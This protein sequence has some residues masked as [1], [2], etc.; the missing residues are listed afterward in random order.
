MLLTLERPKDIDLESLL[1]VWVKIAPADNGVAVLPWKKVMLGE[2]DVSWVVTEP[3]TITQ[4]F[5]RWPNGRTERFSMTPDIVRLH[6][7]GQ[8]TLHVKLYWNM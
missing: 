1:E 4:L 2:R 3:I 7:H 8:N 6:G 5:A